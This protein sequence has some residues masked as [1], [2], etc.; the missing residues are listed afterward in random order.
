MNF[1]LLADCYDLNVLP[2]WAEP[3]GKLLLAELEP[4][5]SGTVLDVGCGTGF[6]AMEV[7]QRIESPGRIVAVD[8]S[9]GMLEVARLKA[10]DHV[11]KRI[12]FQHADVA[13]LRFADD[14]F[15]LVYSN[16]AIAYVT[17]SST[18]LEEMVRVLAPEGKLVVTTP[19]A[20]TFG[21]LYR[22]AAAVLRAADEKQALDAV[23]SDAA[24]WPRP[25]DAIAWV[26][27][28]GLEEVGIKTQELKLV[29]DDG[30]SLVDT[31]LL[32]HGL[33]DDWSESLS[34]ALSH[35]AFLQNLAAWIDE[36][37]GDE[38]FEVPI[39]AAC[40]RGTKQGYILLE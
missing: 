9:T 8:Q 24:L 35:E 11:Q 30:D 7:L 23:V 39:L 18:A 21:P 10:A 1:E 19:L 40:L 34:T 3:F 6:P 25:D 20:G 5:I 2:L 32:R 15:D 38:P 27:D 4:H 31:P 29:F 28:A 13:N 14:V 16:L 12:F 36:S 26:E 22:A 37:R 17:D 33:L